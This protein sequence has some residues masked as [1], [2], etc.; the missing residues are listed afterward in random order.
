MQLLFVCRT[1]EC[2]GWELEW[3]WPL[4]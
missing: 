2:R 1:L 3:L 4:Q